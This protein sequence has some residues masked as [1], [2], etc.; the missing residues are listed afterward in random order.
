MTDHDHITP[1][2]HRYS[3]EARAEWRS[4]HAHM[5]PSRLRHLPGIVY[6]PLDWVWCGLWGVG[7]VAVPLVAWLVVS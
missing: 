7:I 1:P 5:I 2:F 4:R 6:E 3:R